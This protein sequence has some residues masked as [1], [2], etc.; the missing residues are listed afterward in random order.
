MCFTFTELGT[1]IHALVIVL[2]LCAEGCVVVVPQ[3][4]TPCVASVVPHKKTIAIQ[5]VAQGELLILCIAYVT[6]PVLPQSSEEEIGPI[7]T[8]MKRLHHLWLYTV[9]VACLFSVPVFTR[10]FFVSYTAS[11]NLPVKAKKLSR[12]KHHTSK[13]YVHWY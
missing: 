10:F 6:F 11:R 9:H 1:V 2:V 8:V 5:F 7:R 3:G 13:S 4:V 12:A